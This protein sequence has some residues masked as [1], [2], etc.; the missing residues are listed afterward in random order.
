M[1]PCR[2]RQGFV[3]S[4][5]FVYQEADVGSTEFAG[6][7]GMLFRVEGDLNGGVSSLSVPPS[8]SVVSTPAMQRFQ[9]VRLSGS[10]GSGRPGRDGQ[11]G[12]V[13]VA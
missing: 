13:D 12:G 3:V 7:A 9:T 11:V 6:A 5:P 10:A 1:K 2:C 8:R 4:I